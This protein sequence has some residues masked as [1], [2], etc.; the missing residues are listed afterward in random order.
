MRRGVTNI[1]HT[2]SLTQTHTLGSKE[3]KNRDVFFFGRDF[4]FWA[5]ARALALKFVACVDGVSSKWNLFS[6]TS[7][8]YPSQKLQGL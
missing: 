1:V 7:T 4:T 3:E 2:H 8:M 6:R 5:K